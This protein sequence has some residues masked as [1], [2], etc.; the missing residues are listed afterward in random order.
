MYGA[1][2]KCKENVFL[3]IFYL[4]VIKGKTFLEMLIE[5]KATW[6]ER[7]APHF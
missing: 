5:Y 7:A 4:R 3:V 6:T 2:Q 1:P